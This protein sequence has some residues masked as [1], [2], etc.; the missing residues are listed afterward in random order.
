MFK[1]DLK[2]TYM[3]LNKKKIIMQRSSDR[4]F[5]SL[6]IRPKAGCFDDA[7]YNAIMA[8]VRTEMEDDVG[9]S[10]IVSKEKGAKDEYNHMQ[11]SLLLHQDAQRKFRDSIVKI[12]RKL[13]GC[14][15]STGRGKKNRTYCFVDQSESMFMFGYPL[16]EYETF[17]DV[18]VHNVDVDLEELKALVKT[19]LKAEKAARDKKTIRDRLNE[20]LLAIGKWAPNYRGYDL[21]S[22]SPSDIT[23]LTA[24]NI[25]HI[26]KEY[27]FST[28]N[29]EGYV[30]FKKHSD[31]IN[32]FFTDAVKTNEN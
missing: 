27:F 7:W 5:I 30:F 9:F 11:M 14:D 32:L 21:N 25:S 10:C 2:N 29:I 18:F 6:T 19:D 3:Y 8:R 31:V 12:C 28:D 4:V 20:D 15:M 23:K 26:A 1:I 24:S 17:E 16:K 22:P 13:P